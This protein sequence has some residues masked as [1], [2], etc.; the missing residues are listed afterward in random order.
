M[1]V[2]VVDGCSIVWVSEMFWNDTCL[3]DEQPPG[4][5]HQPDDEVKEGKKKML[6]C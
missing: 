4:V 3:C 1:R 6:S 5:H 2:C